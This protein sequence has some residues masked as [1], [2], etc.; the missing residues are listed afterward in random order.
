MPT[1]K[2]N[3][4]SEVPDHLIALIPP[5]P[6]AVLGTAPCPSSPQEWIGIIAYEHSESCAFSSSRGARN[7]GPG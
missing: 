6:E 4:A 3:Q 5:D 2:Q 1:L 7:L